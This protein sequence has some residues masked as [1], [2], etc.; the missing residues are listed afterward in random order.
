MRQALAYAFDFEWTNKNLFYGAYTRTRSYF[1]NSE[2][3]SRGLPG[4]RRAGDP[5][6]ASAGS[7]PEEVFTKEYRPPHGRLGQSARG[8]ARGPALLKEAGWMVR[9]QKLV[10][11]KTGEPMT[12]RDP[13]R[14]PDAGSASPCPS[15]RTS[16]ASAS[17]A[18]VRTVDTAAVPEPH[19]QLRLRHDRD[20]LGPV[21]VARQRAARLLG[22]ARRPPTPG[23]RNLAGIK[24]PVVDKLIDLVIAAPDRQGLVA[25]TRALDRVLLWGHY[26]IPHWH[27]NIFRV[28]YWDKFGR[29]ARRAQVRARLRHVVGRRRQKE[30]ALRQRAGRGA[31]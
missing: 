21:A 27:I 28:A 6:A 8:L 7:V 2:L 20:G 9:D 5:G 31:R 19:R 24:D 1:S 10:N 3:A 4:A 11:A 17:R 13:H 23:S 25:R 14:R 18:R 12:L 30:A 22:I 15:P 16:S 29:P 26:V